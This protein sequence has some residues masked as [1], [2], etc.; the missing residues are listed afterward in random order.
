MSFHG[1]GDVE[2]V[3]G[4]HR[5]APVVNL[6]C[7]GFPGVSSRTSRPRTSALTVGLPVRLGAQIKS[8][9]LT[10]SETIF[11]VRDPSNS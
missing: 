11:N 2:H 7:D 4:L 6:L 9:S 1:A 3:A 10:L 5:G 8:I